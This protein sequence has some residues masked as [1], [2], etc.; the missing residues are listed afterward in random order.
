MAVK[1]TLICVKKGTGNTGTGS[2]V[3][4]LDRIVAAITIP[5]GT[6]IPVDTTLAAVKTAL[7]AGRIA[8]DPSMRYY[9][10][11]N[12]VP[13]ADNSG[14]LSVQT[15]PDGT[16]VITGEGNYD[17]TFDLLEGKNCLA[18]R[19]RKHNGSNEDVLLVTKNMLLLGQNGTTDATMKGFDPSILFA[20]APVLSPGND[21]VTAYRWRLSFDKSQLADNLA[22]VDFGTDPYLRT[23][24]GLQDVALNKISR[25]TTVIKVGAKTNCGTVDLYPLYKTALAVVGAWLV[26]TATGAVQTL[27]SVAADD[28]VSGWALTLDITDPD[29]VAGAPVDVSWVGPTDL[30]ALATPV[31]GYESNVI[32]VTV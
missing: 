12:L 16:V 10:I 21:A 31:K 14:D 6:E 19:L 13:Q 24:R 28:N 4:D 22:F 20:L 5:A 17:W 2:C 29:Y 18:S 23:V 15:Y 32:T 30:A 25:V 3:V 1:N 8:N 7:E 11:P 27:A 26:K 9:P